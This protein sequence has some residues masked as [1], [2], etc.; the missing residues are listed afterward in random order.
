MGTPVA[1]SA[2][3][4]GSAPS[5]GGGGARPKLEH[6]YLE[7][8]TPPPGGSLTPGGPCG[9]I[10]FQFNPKELQLTKGAVWKR[11]PAKGAKSAGPPEFQGP[12]P[13]KL[14]AEMF[15][16]ASDTQDNSVVKAVEQLLACCVPTS[17][18]RQQQR[19]SPPWVVFHWGGLT[20]FPGYV[21]KVNAKYTLFTTAGV[22]I[23]AVCKVTMEEISGDTPGQNPTS[24]ALHA[25]RVHRVQA[26]DTLAQLAWRE[27]GDPT[28]WRVIAEANQID[29]PMR[30]SDGRE[31][32][33]PGLDELDRLRGPRDGRRE[34]SGGGPPTPPARTVRE[35]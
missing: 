32:L 23:R 22:P 24:G 4:S 8:R 19:S 31:L 21:S 2:A 30:L 17:E 9:R 15:F 6:A 18:T 16:D 28:V 5:P 33:L 1:F 26:G 34:V 3:G 10:D 25:R 20:G 13:S 11:T 35:G 7:L 12:Q 27:Y 14:I 29:D